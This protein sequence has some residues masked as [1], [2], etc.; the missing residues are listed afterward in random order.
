MKEI[1][2][3]N[4][5]SLVLIPA[6]VISVVKNLISY[7]DDKQ[8]KEHQ[9]ILKRLVKS[10]ER[11]KRLLELEDIK[12]LNI[13]FMKHPKSKKYDD[14]GIIRWNC[15]SEKVVRVSIIGKSIVPSDK[16]RRLHFLAHE[17]NHI[18]GNIGFS[19]RK[20]CG[21][22]M[23]ACLEKELEV[24]IGA[25]KDFK[26]IGVRLNEDFWLRRFKNFRRQCK[27]CLQL[28]EDGKCP[29]IVIIRTEKYLN[30]I[31]QFSGIDLR[32]VIFK[33]RKKWLTS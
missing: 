29:N 12:N 14:K 33:G 17:I 3:E 18:K 4:M 16:D 28:L 10:D 15:T 32:K 21:Y 7:I 11:I 23:R 27:K 22:E 25:Q 1:I 19:K 30:I 5:K 31:S 13:R 20:I 24:N 2:L 8:R 6:R 26:E 9:R